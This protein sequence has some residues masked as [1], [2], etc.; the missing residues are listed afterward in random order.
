MFLLHVLFESFHNFDLVND[1]SVLYSNWRTFKRYVISLGGREEVM[2]IRRGASV[3]KLCETKER[4]IFRKKLLSFI[5][6]LRNDAH[7]TSMKIA[8]FSGPPT[9]LA[10]LL[11]K[12]FYPLD[13]G[14]PI[15]SNPPLFE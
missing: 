3:L 4:L 2:K 8:Q 13:L 10:H 12:F 5:K 11:L 9:L 15:S 7:M 14:W 6:I 1:R